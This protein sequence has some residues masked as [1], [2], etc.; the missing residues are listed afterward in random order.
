VNRIVGSMPVRSERAAGSSAV[1]STD[2]DTPLQAINLEAAISL[3]LS[4]AGLSHSQACG[5]MD[6]DPSL[7]ARQLRGKDNAHVSFQR[8]LRLPRR[9][10]HE[11]LPLLA[12]PLQIT[13]T[14]Q[15]LADLTILRIVDLVEH[16]G[17]FA[18]QMRAL[19]RIG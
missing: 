14:T 13:L 3:A 12:D 19:R 5:Y 15:D 4:R 17:T 10:W 9:F 8:L 18:V 2:S 6:L 16:I 1:H 7:W 11:L